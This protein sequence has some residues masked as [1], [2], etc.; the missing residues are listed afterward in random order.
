M[1]LRYK[2][3]IFFVVLSMGL[4]LMT[5]QSYALWVKEIAATHENTIDV[6]CFSI[7]F[8]DTDSINLTNTYPISDARG[9]EQTPYTFT[10]TNTCS[11]ASSYVVT[12]NTLTSNQIEAHEDEDTQ[13]SYPEYNMKEKVKFAIHE[14][15]EPKPEAGT[16][17]STY[18]TEHL[19][20]NTE[21][22]DIQDLEESI[23]LA[24]GKLNGKDGETQDSKT[25]NLYLWFGENAGNEIM[26]QKFQAKVVV[27]NR[28]VEIKPYQPFPE[29][30]INNVIDEDGGGVV[31][32]NGNGLYRVKHDDA[33][34]E[35]D[36][37]TEA[38]LKE[39]QQ[40]E[41]RYAGPDPNNYVT[42]NGEEAGWRIIGLV[43]VKTSSGIE[44]R[45][46]LIRRTSIGEYSWDSST[47]GVN[48]GYG[49][50]EWSQADLKT[51]LND[52]YY[53]SLN[54]QT[55]YNGSNDKNTSCDFGSTGL[56][57]EAKSMIDESIIW[58]T[59]ANGTNNY[60]SAN[61]GLAKHFYQY[62]RSSNTGKICTD[63]YYC[64]DE[65]EPRT[66]EWSKTSDPSGYH[67]I[68]LMY[69]SDY[70]YATS[71]NSES[72]D[73]NRAGCLAKEMYHWFS[74]SWKTDCA[75]N[76]WLYT[77]PAEH[78]WT[79]SPYSNSSFAYSVFFVNLDGYVHKYQATSPYGVL[80]VV[81]LSSSVF[82]SDGDGSMDKPYTLEL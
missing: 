3:G 66:T 19:N 23:I 75:G 80:P 61:N 72:E 63:A 60:T 76:D 21:D 39:F 59:G 7:D 33:I 46:K 47:S 81:Y 68:G 50:N 51:L 15:N 74:G 71:G 9:L 69:P 2:I 82:V 29:D 8:K 4:C 16:L 70:G 52:Y 49:I 12:L 5:Y 37:Y 78:Y 55:C 30:V 36:G 56:K 27:I 10:I 18:A 1:R 77:L 17:L 31:D 65:V 20:E 35:H 54:G 64:N 24:T 32:E 44:Q 25:Y 38:Q 26:N 11:I 34:I 6:G 45:V 58:N 40:S 62:E 14:Q 48:N 22:I 73:T 28:A 42:F 41:L 53:N 43:N 57:E 67:G 79:I 13:Y